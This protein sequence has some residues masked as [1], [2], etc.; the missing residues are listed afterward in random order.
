MSHLVPQQ[1]QSFN[2]SRSRFHPS[3]ADVNFNLEAVATVIQTGSAAL[4][5]KALLRTN[6]CLVGLYLFRSKDKWAHPLFSYEQKIDWRNCTLSFDIVYTGSPVINASQNGLTMTVLDMSGQAYFLPLQRFVSAGDPTTR[7][8]TI[9]IDFDTAAAGFAGE[10]PVP[11]D[12]IDACFLSFVD[13]TYDNKAALAPLAAEVAVQCDISNIAVTGS[14][15]TVGINTTALTNHELN[16]ADGFADSYPITPSRIVEQVS[17]LGYHNGV[18]LYM[19]FTQ[20]HQLAWDTGVG[21]LQINTGA[22]PVNDPTR[23]WLTDYATRLH[24]AGMTLTI[25][26]SLEILLAF[27]PLAWLQRDAAGTIGQSGWSPPSGFISPASTAG[28]AYLTDVVKAFVA[29]VAATGC[30]VRF[31]AG[32]FWWWP[33][34]FHNDGPA[35]YDAGVVAGYLADT[36]HAVPTPRLATIYDDYSDPAQIAFLTWLQ[37]KLGALTLALKSAVKT[38]TP[39]TDC[40]VLFYTPAI[41]NPL[42][43]MLTLVDFPATQ[44]ASPAW[45]FVQI[46]DYEVIEFNNFAQQLKDLD[47]PVATLGYALSKVEYFSGFNLL[48]AT[49]FVWGNI[50]KALWQA[51]QRK[52]YT[53]ALVWARP[54][55]CRDG[56]VYDHSDWTAYAAALTPP[57]LPT[58]PAG[59]LAAQGWDIVRRSEF[60][61]EL[62]RQVTGSECRAPNALYPRRHWTLN[63]QALRQDAG[64]SYQALASFFESMSGRD[65]RFLFSDPLFNTAVDQPLGTGDG[66]AVD[67]TLTR[68]VG[69]YVEPILALGTLTN[70]KVNGSIVSGATYAAWYNDLWPQ[71]RFFTPPAAAATITA[72]YSYLFVCRFKDDAASFEEIVANLH[73]LSALEFMTVKPR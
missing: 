9:T 41:S 58:F 15:T 45:D 38:A 64:Q 33:G 1:P 60:S 54:Q 21:Y 6:H 72:T 11:W 71:V 44:W 51:F 73:Q 32:E 49:P 47:V 67:F 25:S 16:I 34:G 48:S 61:T 52:S 37:Q 4:R 36:G 18:T 70:V 39:G 23:Q 5:M 43:P 14:N 65:G 28:V 20:F 46:E 35:F 68:S 56:W 27:A 13:A 57:A 12:F 22:T 66:Y 29:V 50:D 42:A 10:I 40:G 17:G 24:T 63:F 30:A 3:L 69:G 62:A 26:I 31:Q 2:T 53:T 55:I 19:G 7:T 59:P 8:A